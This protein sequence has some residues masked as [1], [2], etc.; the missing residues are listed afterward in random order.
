[1]EIALGTHDRIRFVVHVR[2]NPT[3]ET[4]VEYWNTLVAAREY[5]DWCE[6][7]KCTVERVTIE[8]H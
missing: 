8:T 5:A 3:G 7:N 1:M 4:M 2:Y 6:N